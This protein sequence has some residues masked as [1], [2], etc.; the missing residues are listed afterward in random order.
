MNKMLV[1]GDGLLSDRLAV[2]LSP[3]AFVREAYVHFPT[4]WRLNFRTRFC[5]GFVLALSHMLVPP[6]PTPPTA[7]TERRWV[8]DASWAMALHGRPGN[9]TSVSRQNL[10]AVY[11]DGMSVDKML[12]SA[13][14]Q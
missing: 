11:G 7:A 1:S 13:Q 3:G 4:R 6:N 12:S 5:F 10:P 2:T 9:G 8:A 14:C